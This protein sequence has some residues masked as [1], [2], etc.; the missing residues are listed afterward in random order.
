MPSPAG[1]VVA[2]A[3]PPLRVHP[4]L[5]AVSWPVR[6]RFAAAHTM[7]PLRPCAARRRRPRS[8]Y[9]GG[10]CIMHAAAAMRGTSTVP[11][12][13]YGAMQ[14]AAMP[15]AMHAWPSCSLMHASSS[16]G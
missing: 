14:H 8:Y 3:P 13:R 4:N 1:M 9:Y 11:T 12:C 6:G 10:P 15:T 7:P 16:R 5:A 2:I